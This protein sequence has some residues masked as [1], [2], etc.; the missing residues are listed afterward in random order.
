MDLRPINNNYIIY[1]TLEHDT[2]HIVLYISYCYFPFISNSYATR[3][4]YSSVLEIISMSRPNVVGGMD[5]MPIN[6]NEY[7]LEMNGK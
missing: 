2:R 4:I 3:C 1:Y 6:N 7:E 5:L